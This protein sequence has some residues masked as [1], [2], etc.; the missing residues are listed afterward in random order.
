MW[1]S[2]LF[3]RSPSSR[4]NR[5]SVIRSRRHRSCSLKFVSSEL[6]GR[7]WERKEVRV[8]SFRKFGS[9]FALW[10]VHLRR[11]ERSKGFRCDLKES[12]RKKKSSMSGRSARGS[13]WKH[14]KKSIPIS[15]GS[16]S[17]RSSS[18]ELSSTSRSFLKSSSRS[19][20][21]TVRR[22]PF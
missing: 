9:R 7:R 5:I 22:S 2:H 8:S 12:V 10:K 3:W 19:L 13:S 18:E 16:S 15:S 6:V 11:N 20:G 21:I 14:R 1:K 4:K 17:R